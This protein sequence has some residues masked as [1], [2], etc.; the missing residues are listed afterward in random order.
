MDGDN[1]GVRIEAQGG[2]ARYNGLRLT[3]VLLLEQELP[4]EI[5]QVDRVQVN[6]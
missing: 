2:L 6:L 5:G 3:D 4:V 1:V